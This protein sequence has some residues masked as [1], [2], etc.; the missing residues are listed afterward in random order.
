MSK[1]ARLSSLLLISFSS[2]YLL[3]LLI[4][5]N[6]ASGLWGINLFSY[7]DWSTRLPIVI[8]SLLCSSA[9]V[10]ISADL[11]QR[12]GLRRLLVYYVLPALALIVFYLLRVKTHYLGDGILRV[13]ELEIGVWWLPTEPLGQAVN[14]AVFKLTER[15]LG[16]NADAAVTL[17][18]FSGGLLYYYALARFVKLISRKPEVQLISFIVLFV[19][20][21]TVLFCG[22][23]ETYM[24]LPGLIALFVTAGF[25]ASK[26]ISSPLGAYVL[27]LL[28]VLFHFKMLM[29]TPCIVAIS[30][31]RYKDGQ[32]AWSVVGL[33]ILALATA[34][35][36]ILPGLSSLPTLETVSF[37]LPLTAA[38]SGYSLLSQQHWLDVI[39]QLLLTSAAGVMLILATL[40]IKSHP[41]LAKDRPR[42]F[43]LAALPGALTMLLLLHSRLGFAVDWDLY[44]ASTLIVSFV[45]VV[46]LTGIGDRSLGRPAAIAICS[47]AFL[48]FLSFAAV[49]ARPDTAIERQV[50]ILSLYGSEGAIGFETLG[51]DLNARG[52]KDLAEQMWMKSLRLRPHV[53]LYG[54]LA[55]LALDD[56][57]YAEAKYYSEKGLELDPKLAILWNHLAVAQ[58]R[59]GDIGSSE[60]SFRTALQLAPNNPII[61]H[62]FAYMLGQAGR[63]GDAA[64]ESRMA[65]GLKPNDATIL[66]SL[67]VAQRMTGKLA[68]AENVLLQIQSIDPANAES[69]LELSKLYLQMSDSAKARRVLEVYLGK[70]SGNPAAPRVQGALDQI[71]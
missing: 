4:S 58:M 22:Y 6:H 12:R 20:G 28:L 54:N 63:W 3:L 29:L 38:G 30:Y 62:N 31:F 68:E 13:R 25:R 64:E 71:Q 65:A 10:F 34:A 47:V 69:Y 14:Y 40:G 53:R 39:S 49:N 67:A 66:T 37:I 32:R 9:A 43:L 24:L 48:S 70:Y 7:F 35:V 11:E 27:F 23:T 8:A 42:V 36:L 57:R 15:L 1:P 2:L 41:R 59:Y 61:H 60:K 26:S 55:Q 50:D 51:N 19:S 18:S 44:S 33:A 52:Q 17:V 21:L 45:A 16:F 56:G 5:T 46:Q